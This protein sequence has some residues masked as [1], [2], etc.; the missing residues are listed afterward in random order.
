MSNSDDRRCKSAAS[1]A[2]YLIT[3]LLSVF[4]RNP[5]ALHTALVLITVA[6]TA[7]FSLLFLRALGLCPAAAVCGAIG[8]G[9]TTTVSYWLS[10]VMFLSALCWAIALLWL[11]TEFT[12]QA[13]WLR[14]L[15]IAFATYSLLL[16]AYP[17]IIILYGYI[18]AGYTVV[19]LLQMPA[20]SR[21]KM[22]R[23]AGALLGCAAVGALASL[24]VYLDVWVLLQES[25]RASGLSDSFFLGVTTPLR[26][27]RDLA[28]YLV[29]VFD[30]SWLGNAIEPS[31][32]V[33]FEGLS[34]TPIFASLICTSF[35]LRRRREVLFWQLAVLVCLAATVIPSLYIFAV[36]HLGFG[37]SLASSS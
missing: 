17:Q 7:A 29:T 36:H 11:I 37:L 2:P 33:R 4:T 1:V 25:G 24:P 20:G 23:I 31:F 22:L 3:N 21:G 12:R 9:F 6:L 18:I 16:A 27:G 30:W 35:L 15:G 19:R 28:T 10:F 5:F 34:F 32:P 14:A 26:E 8:L 13:S